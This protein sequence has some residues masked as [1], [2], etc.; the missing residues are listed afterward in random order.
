LDD[1][2][3]FVE[4]RTDADGFCGSSIFATYVVPD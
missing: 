3:N 1:T 2:G 4:W